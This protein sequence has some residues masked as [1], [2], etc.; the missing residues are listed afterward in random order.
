[1]RLLS[2]KKKKKKNFA[3]RIMCLYIFIRTIHK[4]IRL[5]VTFR[6]KEQGP[7][8]QQKVNY[9]ILVNKIVKGLLT[10]IW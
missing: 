7:P 10:P 9:P 2:S 1:M 6:I 5:L 8:T 3:T 4:Y